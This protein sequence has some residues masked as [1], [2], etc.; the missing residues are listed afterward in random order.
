MGNAAVKMKKVAI[1]KEKFS[2]FMPDNIPALE[3]CVKLNLKP[4]DVFEHFPSY[5]RDQ[6]LYYCVTKGYLEIAFMMI[7]S[8]GFAQN[9]TSQKNLY[10][11]ARLN[12]EVINIENLEKNIKS[13]STIDLATLLH[14]G[15]D[16]QDERVMLIF[17]KYGEK[18]PFF[19]KE[20]YIAELQLCIERSLKADC[21]LP[22]IP[23]NFWS[24]F[25]SE[26]LRMAQGNKLIQIVEY[27]KLPSKDDD[28]VH[29]YIRIGLV[30]NPPI[31]LT[32]LNLEIKNTECPICLE[33]FNVNDQ[34]VKMPE[35]VHA[36]CQSCYMKMYKC[37]NCPVCRAKNTW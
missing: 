4:E 28:K 32:K 14:L 11:R 21:F 16:V 18:T 30:I 19:D 26:E 22:I 23:Q 5:C 34:V 10:L 31:T 29:E 17:Q 6:F 35:C 37:K 25:S 9:E 2:Y 12:N 20:K 15:I 24:A 7:N 36:M 1:E 27:D 13:G 3:K 33:N 8:W